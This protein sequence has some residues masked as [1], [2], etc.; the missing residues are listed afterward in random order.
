M[1]LYRLHDS[2]DAVRDIQ[3]RLLGLAID[4]APD[5]RGEFGDGTNGAVIEFQTSRGLAPDGIVGPETWRYLYEA[6]YRLGDRLLFL[7]RPMLRGED[8]SDLQSRLNGIGF[9]AG[10]VDGI[11]GLD[12]Q[13]AVLDFQRNRHLPEDGKVGP[14]VLT[15]LQLITRATI[16]TGRETIRERE[17]LRE[18]PPTVVGARVYLDSACRSDHE[19]ALTWMVASRTALGLQENGAVPLLSRSSDVPIPERVR[20]TRANRL[21]AEIIVSVALTD[22]PPTVY[23]FASGHGRSEAGAMLAEEIAAKLACQT[24]GRATAILKETR[25]PAVVITLAEPDEQTASAIVEG[26]CAFFAGAGQEKNRR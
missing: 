8:V 4:V 17:W 21:G 20:A 2:G 26:I 11:F 19:A 12:T 6:G 15:E 1:R 23:Y 18:R 22:G 3:D 25:A 24:D 14:E 7:R 16:R 10:K 5:A 9:D 13:R